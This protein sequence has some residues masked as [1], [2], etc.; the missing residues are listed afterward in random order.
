MED[1]AAFFYVLYSLFAG[2][3][4][5]AHAG[6]ARSAARETARPATAAP[7]EDM[8]SA[9]DEAPAPP[10]KPPKAELLF[11]IVFHVA[12]EDEED[13]WR[14]IAEKV[15]V[16]NEKY[17]DIGIGFHF[18]RRDNTLSEQYNVLDNIR[19]RHKLKKFIKKNFINVFVLDEILDPVPSQATRR[20][21]KWQGRKPSG[22]LAGA[23]IPCK[24]SIPDT[25][26][27]M[28]AD[29]N[30]LTLA[31]ELGHMFGLP[32]HRNP[33]NIMSYGSKRTSFNDKQRAVMRR[34][35]KKLKKRLKRRI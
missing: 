35:A 24:K 14:R 34:K 31:H 4:D 7:L 23:H 16:A 22:R 20:A 26:I 17:A 21:A 1:A 33:T 13:A 19:E 12:S 3:E 29:A 11:E 15:D 9:D 30:P 10:L 6:G 18:S 32:H 28:T 25:Y 8:T 5:P 2:P 27:L